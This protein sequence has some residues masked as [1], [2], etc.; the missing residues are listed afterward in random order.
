MA[1]WRRLLVAA[2]LSLLG[3]SILA[4]AS[5]AAASDSWV[6]PLGSGERDGL[7][8]GATLE[9]A[10]TTA[11]PPRALSA[12]ERWGSYLSPVYS[13]GS[14]FAAVRV[15]AES[16]LPAGTLVQLDVRGGTAAGSWG[17]WQQ[18]SEG[19]RIALAGAPTRLQLRAVLAGSAAASPS[20]RRLELRPEALGPAAA[21]LE[22][23]AAQQGLAATYR[24]FATREGLVGHRTANGHIIQPRD[25]F[26]ALP[27]W[28]VL[29]SR[30]GHE[31]QV[32]ITYRGRSTVVP[33]WDVGP[34]NTRD[35]YWGPARQSYPDLPVGLPMAQAAYQNGYNGGRDEFG[36]RVG[37]P[38]GIDIADGAFWDDLGMVD[39]DWVEVSFLWLGADPGGPKPPDASDAAALV[40]NGRDWYDAAPQTPDQWQIADC[41]LNGNHNWASSVTGEATHSASWSG[42][43]PSP[44]VYEVL[45]YIPLC[46]PRAASDARYRIAHDGALSE[47]VVDQRAAEGRWV[48]LG[49]YHF[50]GTGARPA[51]LL[52]NQSGVRERALRFDAVKWVPRSDTQAP[53][54]WMEAATALPDGGYL[55]RWQGE[56]DVTG[57]ATYDVQW[58]V[59]PDGAWTDWH[60][61]A[62]IVQDRF[63]PPEQ[64]S[65][66]FRV[67]ARDW[68]GN[69]EQYPVEAEVTLPQ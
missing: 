19:A 17:A 68:A 56:D 23:P 29:A 14:S 59:L 10:P 58:R 69:Q 60:L 27:N 40:D 45:A 37:L 8:A 3:T 46:G 30:G 21:Q 12:F 9:L 47:V 31:Y 33:V 1:S 65:Y 34:W 32:R 67:R 20:L 57:V 36:R 24:I 53:E 5:P 11:S 61:G 13:D 41:G 54:A 18:V 22:A 49:T 62:S 52:D 6:V 50:G 51:V 16:E 25:R 4:H 26:V 48:S 38:N 43:L 42:Q 28:G 55:V 66:G 63:V 7:D 15:F 39:S 64:A 44:G 35:D 2:S